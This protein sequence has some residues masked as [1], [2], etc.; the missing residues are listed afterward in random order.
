[1]KKKFWMTFIASLITF[2]AIFVKASPY[3]INLNNDIV[4]EKADT[5]DVNAEEITK[6]ETDKLEE[7]LDEQDKE[8]LFLLMGIDDTDG[9]VGI[10]AVKD[11]T[12]ESQERYITTGLRSDTM[13]LCKFNFDTGK[14][15]MISIPRDTKTVIPTI[16][17]ETKI[18][19]AH[20]YGGPNLAVD[21]LA[22]LLDIDLKY[23]VTVDYDAV[24]EI[25]DEIGGVEVDVPM[26]MSYSDPTAE[27]PLY[28]DLQ[29]GLQRLDGDKSLQFLRYRTNNAMTMG[30]TE[31]DVGR[32]ESQ[33]KF[34][35][36]MIDE[37]LQI[38]NII[39]LPKLAQTY[40]EYVDTNIPWT[41]V[42]RGVTTIGKI[43]FSNLNTMI[44]PGEGMYIGDT[45]YYILDDMELDK[46][47]DLYLDEFKIKDNLIER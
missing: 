31:G 17:G 23:Y 5:I 4:D 15:T 13:I 26:R 14:I 18:N 29:K 1:M 11:K 41:E 12:K 42:A 21:A 35:K 34:L 8:I 47:I 39:K 46:M 22:N 2:S 43:D 45:S 32:I 6:E 24:K 33:Q 38:K 19:H 10:D 9:I 37:V 36:A 3:L 20:S 40:F 28:I 16:N 25:V 44:L 27:P 30:Y 7:E